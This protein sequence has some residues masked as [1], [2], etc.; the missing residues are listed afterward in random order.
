MLFMPVPAS[1]NS[2]KYS[3]SS[4]S[5]GSESPEKIDMIVLKFAV[6]SM[7]SFVSNCEEAL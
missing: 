3:P 2:A 6:R 1:S 4:G 5:D 7:N